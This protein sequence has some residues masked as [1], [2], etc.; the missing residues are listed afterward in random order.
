MNYLILQTENGKYFARRIGAELVKLGHHY[1]R[2]SCF[3]INKAF[4]KYP[5][6]NPENL[7]IHSRA[8]NPTANWMKIL[9]RY[10]SS[11][12]KVINSTNC[13]IHTSDKFQS[14]ID[15]RD[16]GNLPRTIDIDL[17][18]IKQSELDLIK[19]LF[20]ANKWVFK[21][22]YSL[23]NGK[24]VHL[25]N[26]YDELNIENLRRLSNGVS[27]RWIL[28]EFI[29]FIDKL[30]RVFVIGGKAL[31]YVTFDKK[32]H[33]NWKLSTCLN[34]NQ[35]PDFS[36]NPKLLKFAEKI[37]EKIKGEI[38][39][40]DVFMLEHGELVLSEVNTACNLKYHEEILQKNIAKEIAKYLVE[41][42]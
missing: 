13:L 8:A 5:E 42:I 14:S 26:N 37:Q 21:T 29:P 1:R 17:R 18:E 35:K 24:N 32:E 11:G 3:S 33:R 16:I 12:Y 9:K 40:I 20:N 22:R 41:R 23:G 30:F 39:F 28:Q 38:N 6:W 10:E 36:P 25:I 15:L 34:P 7:I 2:Y 19:Q 31:P 4:A 27:D